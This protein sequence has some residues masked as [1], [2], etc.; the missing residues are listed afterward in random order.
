MFKPSHQKWA[1]TPITNPVAK[2]VRKVSAIAKKTFDGEMN[3]DPKIEEKLKKIVNRL[4]R[5][6]IEIQEMT[7]GKSRSRSASTR[8]KQTKSKLKEQLEKLER[9]EKATE[10]EERKLQTA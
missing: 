9:L 2:A 10:E 6:S 1:Q 4:F 5:L 3:V 8:N 7:E